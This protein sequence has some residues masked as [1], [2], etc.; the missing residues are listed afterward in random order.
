[1]KPLVSTSIIAH[2]D[3]LHV[4]VPNAESGDVPETVL[5]AI[6]PALPHR[7]PWDPKTYYF[8]PPGGM[9]GTLKF[10]RCGQVFVTSLSGQA[11]ASLRK[12]HCFNELLRCFHGRS[13]RIS[14]LDAAVD[15]SDLDPPAVVVGLYAYWVDRSLR[16]SQRKVTHIESH[17]GTG[18]NGKQTGTVYFGAKYARVRLVVYDKQ[19][20]LVTQKGHPDPG[21]LVRVELRFRGGEDGVP[22]QLSHAAD[23]TAVFWHFMPP[24]ILCPPADAKIPN[25]IKS[26]DVGYDLPPRRPAQPDESLRRWVEQ[27]GPEGLALADKLGESGRLYLA[28][29]LG[30]GAA[31]NVNAPPSLQIAA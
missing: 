13:H 23:P 10:E 1:M 22:L 24:E 18:F 31:A 30:I 27:Y 5:A 17:I 14:R 29:L 11:L 2:A 25:W 8:G 12:A 4:T 6:A 16:L 19:N 28:Q 26:S 7:S 20:E 21:P 3:K 15:I 9:Q